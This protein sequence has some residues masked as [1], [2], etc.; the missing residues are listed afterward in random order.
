LKRKG[1]TLIELLVVIA[2]IAILA[3]ILFPVFAKAREA[4]RSATCKSN[5]KQIGLA[6]RMYSSDYDECLPFKVNGRVWDPVV[7]WTPAI[8]DGMYWGRFYE[9]YTKNRQIFLCPSTVSATLKA[10]F[11]SYGLNGRYLDGNNGSGSAYPIVSGIADAAVSDAAGTIFA[12]DSPE[13]RMEISGDSLANW[14]RGG[15]IPPPP[16]GTGAEQNATVAN[17]QDYARHSEMSN[18]LYF[19][20]HVKSVKPALPGCLSY[21]PDS[22]GGP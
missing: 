1:F 21:T 10:N 20:G 3:A 2:I 11:S 19:D 9:P 6:V 17:Q 7:P 12:H 4:A 15:T 13:E 18:V 16:C 5:L 8:V 14:M 22:D